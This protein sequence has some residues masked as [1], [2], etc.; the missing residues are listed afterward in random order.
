LAARELRD[1]KPIGSTG[2][3]WTMI[4]DAGWKPCRTRS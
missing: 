1:G 4:D 3:S 2:H